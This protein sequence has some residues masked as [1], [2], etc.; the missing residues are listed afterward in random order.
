MHVLDVCTWAHVLRWVCVCAW[1]LCMGT[2]VMVSVCMHVHDFCEWAHVPWWICMYVHDACVW[3]CVPW[4][5]CMY[6][7]DVCVWAYVP[8]CICGGWRTALC[9]WFLSFG[10]RLTGLCCVCLYLPSHFT[11]LKHLCLAKRKFPGAPDSFPSV[12]GTHL[13]WST[14]TS[15]D[16]CLFCFVFQVLESHPW[17][18]RVPG[19]AIAYSLSSH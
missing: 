18:S 11:V 1:C 8:C 19:Q 6:M 12:A 4:W 7:H 3:S 5:M 17:L 14:T 2:C 10:F 9:I 13:T 15:C 16:Y